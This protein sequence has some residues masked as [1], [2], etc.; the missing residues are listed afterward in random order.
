V[1]ATTEQLRLGYDATYYTS[2]T[3][4]ATGNL[5]IAPYGG[6]LGVTGIGAFTAA[7]DA[8]L[9]FYRNLVDT[10]SLQIDSGR[11]YLYNNTSATALWTVTHAGLVGI[12]TI[13][14]N[15]KC[16]IIYTTEQLRLGYDAANYASLTV[17]AAG[18]LNINTTSGSGGGTLNIKPADG[19]TYYSTVSV[20]NLIYVMNYARAGAWVKYSGSTIDFTDNSVMVIRLDATGETV[21]NDNGSASLDFRIE[22][23]TLPNLFFVDASADSV[24]INTNSPQALFHVNKPAFYNYKDMIVES[25]VPSIRLVDNEN[26]GSWAFGTYVDGSIYYIASYDYPDRYASTSGTRL[27]SMRYDGR[28]GINNT[29]FEY[30]LNISNYYGQC[31][32]LI[33]D[34]PGAATIYARFA[35]SAGGDLTITPS[36]GDIIIPTNSKLN[37]GV[38]DTSGSCLSLV[39]TTTAAEVCQYIS[40]ASTYHGSTGIYNVCYLSH[41]SGSNYN[42][43]GMFTYVITNMTGTGTCYSAYGHRVSMRHTSANAINNGLISFSSTIQL[44]ANTGAVAYGW[45]YYSTVSVASGATLTD[46]RHFHATD[47]SGAGT[48][49]TQ[50]GLKIENLTKGA[51]NWSIYTGTAP[52]LFG[53]VVQLASGSA[54]APSITFSADTNCGMYLSATDNLAFCTNG[55]RSFYIDSS[56]NFQISGDVRPSPTA[57]FDI[58]LPHAS[59]P[60]IW[61]NA[62]FTGLGVGIT[63]A[64]PTARAQIV[65]TSTQLI[66]GYDATTNQATF[67]VDGGGL[68]TVAPSGGT[69]TLSSGASYHYPLTLKTVQTTD[70]AGQLMTF[71]G[72]GSGLTTRGY[73]GFTHAG[74]AAATAFGG[75][76]ADYMLFRGETGIHLGI[77]TNLYATLASSAITVADGINLAFGTSSGTKIGTATS[78]KL[79][80]WNATPVVQQTTGASAAT[81]VQNSGNAINDASTFDGYTIAQMAKIIRTLGLAA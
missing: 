56:Q 61:R 44:D 1:I 15:A 75:E 7:G 16:N 58:G 19:I 68:L 13:F 37:I 24:G 47:T 57:S 25:Y 27:F 28:F 59:S 6:T 10:I 32:Q 60:Q 52:S 21:F 55:T 46:L 17:L 41:S 67:F 45:G 80:F 71:Q 11:T 48:L 23:D 66:L 4:S 35:V 43:D 18:G 22:G 51:T 54:S 8:R 42:I 34:Q 64:A 3:V 79:G 50:Y 81:F 36:G 73:I 2:F 74:T 49:T 38:Q 62:Y 31:L 5:T 72:G 9:V 69:V 30:G 65:G 33:Y 53:G 63:A 70:D 26:T 77:S 40:F 39:R 20:N 29:G 12:G 76:V 78:Q 14:P